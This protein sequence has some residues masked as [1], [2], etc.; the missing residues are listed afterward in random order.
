MHAI[1]CIAIH[2]MNDDIDDEEFAGRL[3]GLL[4]FN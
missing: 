1:H 3:A 2:S 4:G